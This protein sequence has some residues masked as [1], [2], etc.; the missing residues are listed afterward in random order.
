M[1]TKY[2][3]SLELSKQLKEAGIPQE[4][5]WYWTPQY[6]EEGSPLILEDRESV[7][8]DVT[9]QEGWWSRFSLS[10]FHV[11]ELGDLLH[12]GVCQRLTNKKPHKDAIDVGK[13]FGVDICPDWDDSKRYMYELYLGGDM[14]YVISDNEAEARGKMLLYLKENKLI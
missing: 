4:S 12:S 6:G 1:N 11:G 7:A 8:S 14:H 13:I 3:T 5:E 2:V 10:A 9:N